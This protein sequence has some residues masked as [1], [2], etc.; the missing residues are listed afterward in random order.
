ME[1]KKLDF[2]DVELEE[3]VK[4]Y[5]IIDDDEIIAF[6][7]GYNLQEWKRFDNF[8]HIVQELIHTKMKLELTEEMLE[9]EIEKSEELEEILKN[10]IET[11]CDE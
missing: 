2:Y 4:G 1:I 8:E 7:E 3:E 11:E 6:Y 10:V 5:L 9:E